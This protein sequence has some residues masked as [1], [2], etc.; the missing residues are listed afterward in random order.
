MR[1]SKRAPVKSRRCSDRTASIA[2]FVG[3]TLGPLAVRRGDT[4]TAR[5]GRHGPRAHARLRPA[6][7]RAGS[8]RSPGGAAGA[9]AGQGSAEPQTV[10]QIL[11]QPSSGTTE[12]TLAIDGQQMRYRN[13]PPQW[14]NFGVAESVGLA[15]R[16]VECHDFR[17]PHAA[18]RQRAGPLRS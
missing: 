9:S 17:R 4:L 18:A 16:D 14:T 1:K 11:P 2:K 5:V 8:R 12:Y 15:G 10:F 13:T 6:D 3:T 7:S